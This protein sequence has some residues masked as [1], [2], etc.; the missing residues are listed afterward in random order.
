L[1]STAVPSS[2]DV[3]AV[4][5]EPS[6]IG[7]ADVLVIGGGMAGAWAATGAARA[8]A[9]VIL[10]DKGY[11]GTSGVT[12]AAGPG[13][14]WVA[15]EARGEAVAARLA[16]GAGLADAAF[17]HR[18]LETTWETLPTLAPF[19]R[20]PVD[21]A[22]RINYRAVRGPEYMR[23]MRAQIGALGVR[24][25]DHHP[26]L[27]LLARADGSVGGARGAKRRQAGGTWEIRA[28]AV[29][30]AAGGAAFLSG[31]LGSQNN[32]GD[33]YLM[34]AEAGAAL[35]GMEFTATFTV[36]PAHSTMTRAMAY[37][38]ASYYDE[39]GRDLDAPPFGYEQMLFLARALQRGRVFCSLHRLP[40]DI[41]AR[42]HTISPNVPLVFDRLGVDPYRDN[43]EVTMH[44]DGTVRGLGGVAVET[45]AG[46]TGVPGLFVA[47]DNASR[48]KV[49]GAISG[50]GNINAAWALTSGLLA[51]RAAAAIKRARAGPLVPMGRTGLRPGGAAGSVNLAA[52]RAV[53]RREMQDY[54][55]ALFRNACGLAASR[56]ALDA[57]WREIADRAESYDV[58]TR[59]TAALLASARW[60]VA[61]AAA[62][63]ETRGMHLRTD[64][65]SLDLRLAHRFRIEGVETPT[66]APD[67]EAAA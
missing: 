2:I 42:L 20:F 62:R 6:E 14:W 54:D 45:V 55:R 31:L 53:V 49:A 21:D 10:V 8:G 4:K 34:A 50:G 1:V 32:T 63:R 23:A 9:S 52:A 40:D 41:K 5:P 18:I 66:I 36:A 59:E 22:G 58:R 3:G 61:A 16:A 65:P 15:P 27:E 11:C 46:A 64:A 38:F 30:L 19:Y 67:L 48:E 56:A 57:A 35:S 43:F 39:E 44:T 17:M 26:A 13:H 7:E 47:G 12:A 29:V 60:S 37:A 24:V 25:L 33:G 28:G 51:G